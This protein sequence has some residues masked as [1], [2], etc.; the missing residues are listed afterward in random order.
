MMCLSVLSF[1]T[2][3]SPS[4][5]ESSASDPFSPSPPS[6]PS[7]SLPSSSTSLSQHETTKPHE[8]EVR[9]HEEATRGHEKATRGNENKTTRTTT[10]PETTRGPEKTTR[11]HGETT[12]GHEKATRND[13]GGGRR[14]RG[15]KTE[16]G[17]VN[18]G[19]KTQATREWAVVA[20]Q[21][22]SHQQVRGGTPAISTVCGPIIIEVH[23][24]R[25]DCKMFLSSRVQFRLWYQ[26]SSTDIHSS[27]TRLQLFVSRKVHM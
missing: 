13:G 10:N 1:V 2:E 9:G 7:P 3:P 25:E 18:S 24:V 21:G 4:R 23:L 20:A 6:A 12:R 8:R 22:T 19:R 15:A 16:G 11:G 14:K 27:H 26:I 5:E 17:S